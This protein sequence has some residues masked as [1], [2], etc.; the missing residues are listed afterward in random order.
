VA[1]IVDGVTKIGKVRFRSQTERQAENYRK[2]LLSMAEDARVI[3]IKLA[4]RLHNMRT[5]SICRARSSGG[6]PRRPARSTRPWRIG[7]AWPR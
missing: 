7:S 4:D 3:L 6:S 2:L 5:W 1:G